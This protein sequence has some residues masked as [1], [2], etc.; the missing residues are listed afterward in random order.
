M[1]VGTEK[2]LHAIQLNDVADRSAG[3]VTLDIRDALRRNSGIG[4][5]P[6]KGELLAFGIGHQQVFSRTIVRETHPAHQPVDPVAVTQRV[7]VTLE[8]KHPRALTRSQA[9]RAAIQRTTHPAL[10][11]V[12][13]K[14]RESRQ[15][16]KRVSATHRPRQHQIRLTRRQIIAGQTEGVERRGAR[17][18]Q[19]EVRAT[20]PER[21]SHQGSRSPGDTG[22][23]GIDCA[24]TPQPPLPQGERGSRIA[25]A[26]NHLVQRLGYRACVERSQQPLR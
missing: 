23:E 15:H 11:R 21:L 3:G 13:L 26:P 12:R 17:G 19:S 4:V 8:G 9:A 6:L 7:G 20:Q 16:K 18:I 24:L 1:A 25:C 2:A 5:G 22:V 14:D 10:G